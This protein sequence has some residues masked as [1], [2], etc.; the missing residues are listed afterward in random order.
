VRDAL[1][2]HLQRLELRSREERDRQGYALHSQADTRQ[3][4]SEATWPEE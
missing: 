2:E 3:W 1:R 4:E